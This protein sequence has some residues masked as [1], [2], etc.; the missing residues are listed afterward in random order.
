MRQTASRSGSEAS[1][2]ACLNKIYQAEM[3]GI[4]RYLQLSFTIMGHN[5]IPI[6]KWFREQAAESMTHAVE[7]GEKI[8][9]LGGQPKLEPVTVSEPGKHSVNDI[10]EKSLRHERVALQL[11]KELVR[12]AGD[13]IALEELARGFVR[14]ETEHV[15]QIQKMLRAPN[16]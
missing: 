10:L 11:Y 1:V 9:A 6:Q 2:I 13:D 4:H 3:S 5:R 12:L 8:T 16:A 7:I 15:E 14:A